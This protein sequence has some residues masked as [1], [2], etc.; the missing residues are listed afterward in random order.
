MKLPQIG[1]LGTL[2]GEGYESGRIR[3]QM[4]VM[5]QTDRASARDRGREGK[6]CSK[7]DDNVDKVKLEIKP[8]DGGAKN[9]TC[10][11]ACGTPGTDRR[12]RTVGR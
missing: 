3:G 9:V 10:Q 11:V 6:Q 4:K 7:R 8:T 2:G 12:I 5:T 1:P